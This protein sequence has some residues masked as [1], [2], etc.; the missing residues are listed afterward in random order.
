MKRIIFR[1]L[2]FLLLA[3]SFAQA[4]RIEMYSSTVSIR[5]DH[6][7]QEFEVNDA[8]EYSARC[9][10]P[11]PS[12]WGEEKGTASGASITAI[13]F[14]G[15]AQLVFP[16]DYIYGAPPND[17][18][19]SRCAISDALAWEIFGTVDAT[20]LEVDMSGQK[21]SVCGV[22]KHRESVLLFYARDGFHAAE[23]SGVPRTE[24]AYRY[25]RD[26]TA[27]CGLG[28]PSQILCGEDSVLFAN[29]LCWGCVILCLICLISP[30]L[31]CLRR[32]I[33]IWMA[34][35]A[36]VLLLPVWM[37]WLPQWWI[38]TRWS[39]RAFW[40]ALWESILSRPRDWITLSPKL[41]DLPFKYASCILLPASLF[42]CC[43]IRAEILKCKYMSR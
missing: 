29:L 9:S 11:W 43:V 32:P 16:A 17:L 21:Y 27:A 35:A 3:V 24:D 13:R 30:I 5:F 34:V 36:I 31:N 1:L 19:P 25:A 12:F 4:A 20:G 42:A 22:F 26:Y 15:D 33:I 39:D 18:T 2:L 41:R 14:S 23:L 8:R 7:L 40:S 37:Q 28:I 38:P 6:P 10:G